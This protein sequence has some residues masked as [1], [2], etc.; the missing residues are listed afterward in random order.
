MAALRKTYIMI[1]KMTKA[2][3]EAFVAFIGL[4]LLSG[5]LYAHALRCYTDV[6][7]TQVTR[8]KESEGFRT[9]FTKYNDSK[10]WVEGLGK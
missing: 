2:L 7:A 4:W 5:G 3:F 6:E 8:C 10:G 1:I 9:C